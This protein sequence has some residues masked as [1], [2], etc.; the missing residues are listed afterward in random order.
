M[1]RSVVVRKGRRRRKGKR[2]FKNKKNCR[3]VWI[4]KISSIP[5]FNLIVIF[6]FSCFFL[7]NQFVIDYFLPFSSSTTWYFLLS[8]VYV[9]KRVSCALRETKISLYTSI[10]PAIFLLPP[11]QW[12]LIIIFHYPLN[13]SFYGA[14]GGLFKWQAKSLVLSASEI[15]DIGERPYHHFSIVFFF[16]PLVI[17][18]CNDNIRL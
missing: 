18:S 8:A 11:R 12:R 15:F 9:K 3:V 13:L 14:M 7:P 6:R 16:P 2:I 1:S 10:S 5:V 4:V 17:H